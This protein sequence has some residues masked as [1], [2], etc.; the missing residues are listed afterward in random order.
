M[1]RFLVFIVLLLLLIV[2]EYYFFTEIFSYKRLLILA[3]SGMVAM[4]CL[5]CLIRFFKRSVISS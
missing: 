5:F 3:M 1:K 4:G 2:A